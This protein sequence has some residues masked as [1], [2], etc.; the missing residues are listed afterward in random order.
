TSN[1]TINTAYPTL[2]IVSPAAQTYNTSE[3]LVNLSAGGIGLDAIWFFNGTDNET[4][5]GPVT[6]TFDEG[7]NILYAWVNDT[8]GRVTAKNV[9]FTVD[10]TGPEIQFADPTDNDS[11]TLDRDYI[12][13]NVTA[14]DSGSGL[15]SITVY[16]YN[17][18]GFYD[19]STSS[20]QNFFV[21]WTGLPNDTYSF[22]A[23][24][25]DDMGN[26]NDTETREVTVAAS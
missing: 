2:T 7:S 8:F 22:N 16:L 5:S 6:R 3:I 18:T 19:S 26:F 11:A 1:V 21:N 20:N 24:A 15:D 9:T 14:T 13:I 12:E 10:T 17:S 4:Y 25:Y 23:T